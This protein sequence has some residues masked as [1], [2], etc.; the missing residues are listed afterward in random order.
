MLSGGVISHNRDTQNPVNRQS[1][2]IEL[3]IEEGPKTGDWFEGFTGGKRKKI[4]DL[5]QNTKPRWDEEDQPG[6]GHRT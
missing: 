4:W 6:F 2:G 1:P 5:S 3:V